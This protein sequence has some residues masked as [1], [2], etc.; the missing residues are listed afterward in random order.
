[1]LVW[2]KFALCPRL[3]IFALALGNFALGLA[4]GNFALGLMTFFFSGI[5]ASIRRNLPASRRLDGFALGLVWPRCLPFAPLFIFF[6][7]KFFFLSFRFIV[8]FSYF[9]CFA[10][11]CFL[12]VFA[13][14]L[15][16]LCFV[17][18]LLCFGIALLWLLPCLTVEGLN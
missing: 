6:V 17:F 7:L 18:A 3:G 11:D 12:L 16:L 8:F 14:I 5:C 13:L 10:F 15:L 4:L 2:R 9:F 1:M